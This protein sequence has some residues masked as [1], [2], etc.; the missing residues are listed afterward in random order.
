LASNLETK[1]IHP[2]ASLAETIIQKPAS[3]S[4]A[5]DTSKEN[6]MNAQ[7]PWD[8]WKKAFFNWE[9]QT[10]KYLEEVM[11]SPLVLKPGGMLL[12]SMTKNRAKTNQMM[13]QMWGNMGLPTKTDQERMLHAINQL[14]SKIYDLE[15]RLEEL[16]EKE[17]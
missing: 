14:Q 12:G 3:K 4:A 17:K 8:L 6:T 13:T 1:L 15:E 7:T 11:K 9:N 16:Q 2:I 10:A 5:R